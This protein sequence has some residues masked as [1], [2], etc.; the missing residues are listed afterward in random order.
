M[1]IN[2]ELYAFSIR[3]ELAVI[4]YIYLYLLINNSKIILINNY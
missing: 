3:V 4:K 2:V 1:Y